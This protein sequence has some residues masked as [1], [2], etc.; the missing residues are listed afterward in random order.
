MNR[1]DEPAFIGGE[2]QPKCVDCPDKN[3]CVKI[4]CQYADVGVPI[5]LKPKVKIEKIET[6]CM[7]EPVVCCGKEEDVDGRHECHMMITQKICVKVAVR[8]N[9]EA[10][11]GPDSIHCECR[12][13]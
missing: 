1:N 13:P 8:Y 6:E 10:E 7:G 12:R 9:V 2:A 3:G 4:S 5:C 11:A